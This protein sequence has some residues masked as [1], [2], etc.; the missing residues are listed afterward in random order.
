MDE[1]HGGVARTGR[2]DTVAYPGNGLYTTFRT[3]IAVPIFAQGKADQMITVQENQED[4]LY[5]EAAS[6]SS[7]FLGRYRVIGILKVENKK[8]EANEFSI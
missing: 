3:I 7:E 2:G 5:P 8:P 4:D 1:L 6:S